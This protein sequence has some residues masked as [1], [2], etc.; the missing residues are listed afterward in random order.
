MKR[1]LQSI[2]TI[3]FILLISLFAF[4]SLI[5]KG[6]AKYLIVENEFT[7][8]ENAFVLSGGAFDR[9]NKAAELWNSNKINKIICTGANQSPDLKVL[10]F[11]TLESDLTKLQIIKNGVPEEQVSLL[12]LGTSTLEESEVILKYC[13]ENNIDEIVLISSKF[14]TKRIQ[15]VFKKKFKKENIQIYIVAAPNSV[16]NEMEWWENEYGLIALNNEYI[17]QLYYLFKY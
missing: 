4:K 1:K 15:Q 11:D 16:Y 12:K 9:G 17:K 2:L 5:L 6:L 10:K 8:I 7:Y 3:L 14:H 13:I